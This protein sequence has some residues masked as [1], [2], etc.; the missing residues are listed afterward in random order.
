M[1]VPGFWYRYANFRNP[2]NHRD[3]HMLSRPCR[4]L[5]SAVRALYTLEKVLHA[6]MAVLVLMPCS[7]HM[8]TAARLPQRLP[9]AGPGWVLS[10]R[11]TIFVDFCARLF[12]DFL[13]LGQTIS[14]DDWDRP[15]AGASKW[16]TRRITRVR[17]KRE[18]LARLPCVPM[19]CERCEQRVA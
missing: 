11:L 15:S 12:T 1:V 3:Y 13:V 9:C 4:D 8:H 16:T 18:A 14:A 2:K 17:V 19:C 6:P 10:A 7:V 5:G